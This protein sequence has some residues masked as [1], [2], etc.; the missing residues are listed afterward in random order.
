[1]VRHLRFNVIYAWQFAQHANSELAP[2]CNTMMQW[3]GSQAMAGVGDNDDN[4]NVTT[5][6]T[7]PSI[8]I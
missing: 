6:R 3:D 5:Y 7:V 1:M 4:D 2:C 8:L